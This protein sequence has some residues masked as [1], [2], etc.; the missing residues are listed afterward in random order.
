M[1][2]ELVWGIKFTRI[3]THYS[4]AELENFIATANKVCGQAVRK[5]PTSVILKKQIRHQ[6]L[7]KVADS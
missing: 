2:S 7:S 3:T 1:E 5:V 6:G 4:Q